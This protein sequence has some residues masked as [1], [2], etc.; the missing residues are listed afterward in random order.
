MN[1]TRRKDR[2]CNRRDL[3]H[4][5]YVLV[6]CFLSVMCSLPIV[7]TF[8]R[9]LHPGIIGS[10][11]RRVVDQRSSPWA[12]IGQVNSTGYRYTRRCTGSLIGSNI[13]ITAAHCV[14]DP[15]RQKPFP[16]H[17]IHFVAGVRGSDWLGHSTAEC[18]YFPPGY[19]YVSSGKIL[20]TLPSDDSVPRRALLRDMV[21][22]V[23]KDAL[24]NITPL[25]LDRAEVESSDTSLVH[26]SYAAD[27]R[28]VLTGHFECHFLAGDRDLWFTDCDTNAAGSGGP[29]LVRRNQD[30][31]LGA[32]MVGVAKGS[33]SIAL[34]IAS[35]I[36]DALKRDCS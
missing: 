36:D 10:D 22:I 5:H 33:A 4:A 30:L 29:V 18:L 6:L 11:D 3:L 9:D 19:E 32:I 7:R 1:H 13:V 8:A 14:M 31:K 34:P 12:A 2:C 35:W 24:N 28:Y 26:A 16:L 15:W 27:R 21:L 25:A 17:Q 20:K 23:L